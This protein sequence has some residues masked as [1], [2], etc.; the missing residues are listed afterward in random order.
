MEVE[1]KKSYRIKKTTILSDHVIYLPGSDVDIRHKDDLKL[2]SHAMSGDNSTLWFNAMKEE[3]SP[4]L[5]GQARLIANGFT[6][7]E[8]IDYHKTFSQVS[9]N[10]S[11]R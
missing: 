2:F 9:K 8:G 5:K 4:W 11:L 10:G 7:K 3:I 1:L 6:H